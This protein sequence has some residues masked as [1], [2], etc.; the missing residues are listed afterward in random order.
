MSVLKRVEKLEVALSQLES[1]LSDRTSFLAN[2]LTGLEQA[3]ASMG[4]T[5]AALSDELTS[6]KALDSKAVLTRLRDAEDNNARRQVDSLLTSGYLEESLGSVEHDSLVVVGHSLNLLDGT[7]D[8][9]SNFTIISMLSGA[10]DPKLK[11][12]LLGKNSGDVF[13]GEEDENGYE[14]F[15]IVHV[16]KLASKTV[17]AE[18]AP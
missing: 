3:V 11:E 4:K 14:E 16:F 13:K 1:E 15:K 7:R 6:T 10:A 17:A 9:T 2:K 18:D 5:L 8:V 12:L